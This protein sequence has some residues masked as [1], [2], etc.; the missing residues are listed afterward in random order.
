MRPWLDGGLCWICLI[1]LNLHCPPDKSDGPA[2]SLNEMKTNNFLATTVLLGV[3]LMSG[4]RALAQD[5]AP[6]AALSN[7]A[8]DEDTNLFRKDVR[9]LAEADYRR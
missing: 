9:S 4:N 7:A 2:L 3:A 5:S 8:S 1:R 6:Q